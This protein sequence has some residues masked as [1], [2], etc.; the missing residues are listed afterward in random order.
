MLPFGSITSLVPL[1]LLAFAYLVYLSFSV[2]N[3]NMPE[4][5]Q[6]TGEAKVSAFSASDMPAPVFYQDLLHPDNN[7]DDSITFPDNIHFRD[8][9][10]IFFHEKICG[11]LIA[12]QCAS[13]F[14]P[15][16]PPTL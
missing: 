2:L 11:G 14:S 12:L 7:S 10:C 6:E 16:P 13:P 4:S 8:Y 5:S 1:S 3:R 15:R 9:V